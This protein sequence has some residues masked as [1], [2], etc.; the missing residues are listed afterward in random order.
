MLWKKLKSIRLKKKDTVSDADKRMTIDIL[1]VLE[2]KSR[3]KFINSIPMK[4]VQWYYNGKRIRANKQMRNDFMKAG[5]LNTDF[6]S[7]MIAHSPRTKKL[8]EELDEKIE[9]D[10]QKSY[11]PGM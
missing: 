9:K 4:Q 7:A 6:A 10:I 2:L 5:L 11:M 3:L 8:M 1:E